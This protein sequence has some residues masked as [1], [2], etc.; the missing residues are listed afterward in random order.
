LSFE[1]QELHDIIRVIVLVDLSKG[2]KVQK[3]WLK[4]QID[5]VCTGYVCVESSDLDKTL[6]QMVDEGL[7]HDDRGT[8]HLTE[9]GMKLGKEWAS[10]L[11][12]KEPILEVVAGL[13]D[14]S[15][16]GLVV[17]ISAFIAGLALRTAI[18]AAFLTLS[19]VAITN[20]S[21]FLLG[22]ITEDLADMITLQSLM[23]YSLSDIPDKDQREKSLK[24]VKDLFAV[25]HKQINR[26]NL[27]AA[28][29]SGTTTFLAGML[30]ILAYFVLPKPLDIVVS[31]GVVGTVVGVFLVRYRSRRSK[32]HWK[33]TL[34]ET[35]VIIAIAVIVSLI[36][37]GS[38]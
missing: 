38:A 31:L 12:K 18:F 2:I 21:S 30:P 35:V 34:L 13:V 15:I 29:I 32:V 7:I 6:G 16:T 4:Q 8:L 37:G 23:N 25:L 3:A 36:I 22:G 1:I 11:L 26:S 24:L 14:G 19:S 27:V 20:F 9:Q 17:I 5:K 28:I 33:V 10:L